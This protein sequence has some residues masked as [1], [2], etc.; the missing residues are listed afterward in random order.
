VRDKP[1]VYDAV[2]TK[3]RRLLPAG[4]VAAGESPS[5]EGIRANHLIQFYAD[6]GGL[7]TVAVAE[8]RLTKPKDNSEAA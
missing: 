1:L 2:I 8:I 7:R 5:Y 4:T 6:P 3:F